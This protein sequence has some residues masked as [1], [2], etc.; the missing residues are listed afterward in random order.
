MQF[1]LVHGAWHEGSGWN[2]VIDELEAL[3]HQATAPTIAG[4]GKDADR[5]DYTM[6]EAVDAVID[7][8]RHSG[9]TDF[10][11]VGHS[12]GG[13]IIQQVAQAIP[14]DV[15]RMV[16]YNAFVL[17]H[18]QSITDEEPPLYVELLDSLAAESDD[19]TAQLPF[20]IWREA[21]TNSV[22]LET[23]QRLYER[24]SPQPMKPFREKLD[25]QRFYELEIP[26]SYLNCLDDIALPPGPE[27]GWHPKFS[28]RLGLYRLVQMPGD[29]EALFTNPVG[30]AA[31]LVEA[32]RD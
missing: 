6:A 17:F 20:P 21:F 7:Q 18:G 24:T 9:L 29:H 16:F 23:S 32:G 31:K 8:I 1:V 27:W 14:D 15:R 10:V 13:C 2:E 26:R 30:L 25:L 5:R 4:N 11:L 22:D 28:Q 12:Y 19:D 3:G